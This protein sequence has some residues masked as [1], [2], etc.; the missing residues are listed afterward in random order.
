MVD[1]PYDLVKVELDYKISGFAKKCTFTLPN[2][3]NKYLEQHKLSMQDFKKCWNEAKTNIIRSEF[4]EMDENIVTSALNFQNYFPNFIEINLN[5]TKD[6]YIGIS[7]N[8]LGG[9]FFL[10]TTGTAIVAR[11]IVKPNNQALF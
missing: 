11:I 9:Y 8:K 3:L 5:R 4:F 2:T 1:I 6:Y 7:E 10:K